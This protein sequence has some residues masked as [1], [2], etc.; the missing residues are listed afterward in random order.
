MDGI[1][2]TDPKT[3]SESEVRAAIDA[4]SKLPVFSLKRSQLIALEETLLRL[5]SRLERVASGKAFLERVL[6]KTN[7]T[8]AQVQ[9]QLREEP[10][11]GV[12]LAER[13]TPEQ[14]EKLKSVAIQA[15]EKELAGLRP[16]EQARVVS[17]ALAKT[18]KS[19]RQ[20]VIDHY[21]KLPALT[22]KSFSWYS[23]G[24]AGTETNEES[25]RILDDLRAIKV[26][27]AAAAVTGRRG[28]FSR[29]AVL[30]DLRNAFGDIKWRIKMI[31]GRKESVPGHLYEVKEAIKKLIGVLTAREEWT[32]RKINLYIRA[33]NEVKSLLE[34]V[35]AKQISGEE[36]RR[37]LQRLRDS[38][39]SLPEFQLRL[40]EI[41]DLIQK[42]AS[43]EVTSQQWTK[44]FGPRGIPPRG[45][46]IRLPG[47]S[48]REWRSM[49]RRQKE[50][51]AMS[52]IARSLAAKLS[53]YEKEF[54]TILES[55]ETFYRQVADRE[56]WEA[57]LAEKMNDSARQWTAKIRNAFTKA[58]DEV[59]RLEDETER[60]KAQKELEQLRFEYSLYF[61]E[62]KLREKIKSA[63]DQAIET[64]KARKLEEKTAARKVSF[65]ST[66]ERVQRKIDFLKP[67]LEDSYQKLEATLSED[68]LKRMYEAWKDVPGGRLK[69]EDLLVGMTRPIVTYAES[70]VRTAERELPEL[71][72]SPDFLALKEK[73][74]SLLDWPATY[75][76]VK[77]L[78]TKLFT[79]AKEVAKTEP[80]EKKAEQE[81]TLFE[82]K[83]YDFSVP[84]KELE[85]ELQRASEEIKSILKLSSVKKLAEE[86]E[87]QGKSVEQAL[88]ERL[89]EVLRRVSKTVFDAIEKTPAL[90]TLKSFSDLL[91]KYE[92]ILDSDKLQTRVTIVLQKVKG[93]EPKLFPELSKEA[94]WA[95]VWDPKAQRYVV[96]DDPLAKIRDILERADFKLKQ[97]LSPENLK[98]LYR[99]YRQHFKF[100]L[101]VDALEAA[102]FAAQMIRFVLEEHPE[103]KGSKEL[104]DLLS[105]YS[106]IVR[107]RDFEKYVEDAIKDSPEVAKAPKD[108]YALPRALSGQRERAFLDKLFVQSAL[109]KEA[110]LRD[111]DIVEILKKH[112]LPD[113]VEELLAAAI[114]DPEDAYQAYHIKPHETLKRKI[115]TFPTTAAK[116]I[117][118]FGEL[119]DQEKEAVL[120][121]VERVTYGA[122]DVFLAGEDSVWTDEASRK[123][124]LSVIKSFPELAENVLR[125]A[126]TL[127]ESEREF[128]SEE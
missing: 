62:E 120:S 115:L 118:Y 37:E 114:E 50:L 87:K 28:R 68:F 97:K 100:E 21:R 111:E 29:T 104:M 92:N 110:A 74:E 123:R 46:M 4:L 58:E 47:A 79:E 48:R 89:D 52:P 93:P 99:R 75:R 49:T 16:E 84:L 108:P 42:S 80:T 18:P 30:R 35:K 43:I 63:V 5:K 124:L 121:T 36:I 39:G 51:A 60:S 109:S 85:N 81:P 116:Y 24:I 9:S 101:Y 125:K 98:D 86:S 33:R 40:R 122:D 6:A 14:I 70:L 45:Y 94:I 69:V 20:L 2:K 12:S 106:H 105:Q 56:D 112:D 13:L 26:D 127:T 96:T 128:L 78:V 8:L 34:K 31:E 91:Q 102:V 38:Y 25:S 59:S 103:L 54:T 61:D 90:P 67:R 11:A 77:E 22:L 53:E 76:R 117:A 15:V 65:E 3:W 1:L 10:E 64:Y 119:T 7:E 88:R 82:M 113:D 57:A 66:E 71:G 83:E 44:D 126:H 73:Y 32:E 19:L 95:E 72:G 41:E 107:E 17:R 23:S 27:P 55:P